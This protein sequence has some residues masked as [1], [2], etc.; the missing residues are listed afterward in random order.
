MIENKLLI[1]E[2][3]K[4]NIKERINLIYSDIDSNFLKFKPLAIDQPFLFFELLGG[5]L[6]QVTP[7]SKWT[8][9]YFFKEA[10]LDYEYDDDYI[11][12]IANESLKRA[13][14]EGNWFYTSEYFIEAELI[15]LKFE[16]SFTEGEIDEIISTPYS[17]FNFEDFIEITYLLD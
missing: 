10:K 16:F 6:N 7:F 2:L 17:F 12:D 13:K 3:E 14:N 5:D 8:P 4:L 11:W 15:K 9:K 1:Q